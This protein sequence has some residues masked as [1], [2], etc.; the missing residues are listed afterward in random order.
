MRR[1]KGRSKPEANT[2]RTIVLLV[3]EYTAS[4]PNIVAN[5]H[6]VARLAMHLSPSWATTSRV[7]ALA[8]LQAGEAA[9]VIKLLLMFDSNQERLLMPGLIVCSDK[10]CHEDRVL[11]PKEK[12]HLTLVLKTMHQ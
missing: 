9:P 11:T 3:R 7:E 8:T 6:L 2:M 12:G 10:L 5:D 4:L 1:L